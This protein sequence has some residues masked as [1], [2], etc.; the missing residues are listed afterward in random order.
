M[1][2]L[3]VG[4]SGWNYDEWETG[5]YSGVKR[6]DRLGHYATL[7]DAVEVNATFYRQ[8]EAAT[9]Q[10]WRD[11]T[12]ARF[13]FAIKGNRYLT[14]NKRLK[15]P[16]EAVARERDNARPLGDKLGAVLWQ[17]PGS[18]AKSPARLRRFCE[19]LG[20][21]RDIRHAVEFRHSSWFDEETA[22]CLHAHAIA[23]CQSD[24]ADWPMWDAVT[25]DMVYLRLHGHSRTYAS[26][27][28][29]TG[30]RK[31]AGLVARWRSEGRSVHV[32]FDNT[33]EGAAPRDAMRLRGLL[34]EA[35]GNS[36]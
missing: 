25:T 34:G 23:N 16:S 31:W 19:A 15:D 33:A 28:S 14:H 24:A 8:Q 18:L 3:F 22:E 17:L 29:G 11:G 32:Y 36:D 6:K 27:Y 7:L 13:R 20:G 26:G 1:P 4:T 9:L 35:G 5:F 12:P 2:G 21:W 10:R 30:L